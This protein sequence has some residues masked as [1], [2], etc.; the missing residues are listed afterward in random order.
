MASPQERPDGSGDTNGVQR[1][2]DRLARELCLGF[3]Y[4]DDRERERA[5]EA[6]AAVDRAQFDHVSAK[7][8]REASVAYVDALWEKDA[9]ERSCTI[10]GRIDRDALDAA[11]W[12]GVRAAFARRASLVGIDAAYAELSTIAW[13]RHKTGGDYW[14]PMQRAQMYELRAALGA[15]EYPDKPRYGQSGFGPEPARYALGVELHDTRAWEQ[16][17][18]VMVPYF[19]RILRAHRPDIAAD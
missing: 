18:R 9:V 11:D 12:S 6:F 16:A 13:R 5:V 19:E 2:A 4:H 7:T 8:A 10:H 14:T 17:E 1:T 15:P 3:K